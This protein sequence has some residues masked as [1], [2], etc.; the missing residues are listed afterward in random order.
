MA[1]DF[2]G[3]NQ[4]LSGT[5]PID[6]LT[7]PFTLACWF[8]SDTVTANQY[9]VSLS[10]ASS[11]GYAITAHG[12][13]AGDP[14]LCINTSGA[15]AQSSSGYTANTWN[16]VAG[17][18]TSTSSKTVYL[19]GGSSGTNTTL[20]AT[21][22]TATNIHIGVTRFNGSFTQYSDAR[23]AEVGVWNVALTAAEIASL[24]RGMTCDKVRPQSLVFYAPLVRDLIDVKGGVTITNNN[25]ATVANHPRVYA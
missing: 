2:N 17:V 24:A 11:G 7:K 22:P 8:N 25:T 23:I 6:G 10:S 9:L 16:H 15:F 12:V 14:V 13:L 21:N 5:A 19:N 20:D 18:F 4:Y 1:Y 3:T